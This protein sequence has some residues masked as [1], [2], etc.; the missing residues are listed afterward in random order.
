MIRDEGGPSPLSSMVEARALMSVLSPF[1]GPHTSR[2]A[3]RTFSRRALG[4][5]AERFDREDAELV[6]KAMLPMLRT[7]LGTA[8]AQLMTLLREEL[9]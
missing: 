9:P 3:V 8:A 4:R 7:L 2:N 6:L 5:E 1:L